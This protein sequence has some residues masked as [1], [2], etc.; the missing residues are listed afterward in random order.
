MKLTHSYLCILKLSI[1]ESCVKL[2]S[3]LYFSSVFYALSQKKWILKLHPI[4][5]HIPFRKRI[6]V[7]SLSTVFSFLFL[8]HLLHGIT[9]ISHASISH[10]RANLQ[11]RNFIFTIWETLNFW[12]WTSG[13]SPA[14]AAC[15]SVLLQPPP[16]SITFDKA[17]TSLGHDLLIY[18]EH[19]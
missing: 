13:T 10:W 3:V 5:S 2:Y 8:H 11:E 15:I 9:S 6:S 19:H 12:T 18:Q 16:P 1:Q 17:L 7:T 4:I 14:E